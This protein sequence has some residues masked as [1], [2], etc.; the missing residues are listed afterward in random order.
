MNI[1]NRLVEMAQEKAIQVLDANANELA[2]SSSLILPVIMPDSDDEPVDAQESSER[3]GQVQATKRKRGRPRKN[4]L[5]DQGQSYGETGGEGITR[6]HQP[7]I[8]QQQS[9]I[10]RGRGRPRKNVEPSVDGGASGSVVVEKRGRGRPKKKVDDGSPLPQRETVV[11]GQVGGVTTAHTSTAIYNTVQQPAH[12]VATIISIDGRPLQVIPS[13]A[14]AAIDGSPQ[15]PAPLSVVVSPS[16]DDANEWKA[17]SSASMMIETPLVHILPAATTPPLL[18]AE[19]PK[20]LNQLPQCV[21]TNSAVDVNCVDR[22]A[23]LDQAGN[24]HVIGEV[25][26][27]ATEQKQQREDEKVSMEREKEEKRDNTIIETGGS[28]KE[29]RT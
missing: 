22:L 26:D 20:A 4:K 5:E 9:P 10:K 7:A 2:A 27:E 1:Y 15:R 6:G 3:S 19:Q 12:N 23:L 11:I 18:L 8:V 29:V 24:A 25:S 17:P 14:V 13:T 28:A 16:V 21:V